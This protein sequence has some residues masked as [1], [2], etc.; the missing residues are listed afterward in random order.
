MSSDRFVFLDREVLK[1]PRLSPPRFT[2]SLQAHWNFSV[3][4]L[5]ILP[6]NTKKGFRDDVRSRDFGNR[7]K[8]FEERSIAKAKEVK[9]FEVFLPWVTSVLYLAVQIVRIERRIEVITVFQ[10]L[11]SCRVNR[12][13]ELKNV[14]F[15]WREMRVRDTTLLAEIL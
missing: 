9:I 10:L 2:N 6:P 12:T 4:T 14:I 7:C 8:H 15:S 3:Y 1:G 11:V 5:L 13:G